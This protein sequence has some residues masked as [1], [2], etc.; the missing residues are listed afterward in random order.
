VN[1]LVHNPDY[2]AYGFDFG[3]ENVVFLPIRRDEIRE[4][5]CLKKEFIDPDR[6]FV[7]VPLAEL[8][9]LVESPPQGLV[10]NPPRFIFHT[11]YCASTFLS[12]CLDVEGSSVSLRE[13][14]LLL[15]AAN[16]KRMQWQSKT[17]KLDHRHFPTLALALLQKHATASE[18]L[19][20]KPVNSVNNI[21][22]E[23]LQLASPARSLMLYTDARNFVLSTL[24]KGE[25]GKQTI[26]SMFD[27]L[28]CDFPHLS[29]LQLTHAI[30]MTDLRI[31]M[32]LWRLQLEQAEAALQQ[33]A[34]GN[35][36][37]SL[38]GEELIE[39]PLEVLKA[40]NKLLDLG[41]AQERLE[42]IVASDE[43]FNDAKNAGEKF[44]KTKRA[45][46]YEK[47]EQFYGADLDDGLEWLQRN[48]PG[49]KLRPDLTGALQIQELPS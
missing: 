35:E 21:I 15:D 18:K 30:H 26:R 17:T 3:T 48:N 27:L 33:F 39:R 23:L 34:P 44:S 4:V 25:G 11:A 13:P 5:S 16:A 24:K 10:D 32:T 47:L 19:V 37:A 46:T 28:R 36:M 41:F 1:D 12:R 9:G 14:Q 40:T 20:I 38:Y 22:P 43:R 7:Q 42:A 8:V 29:N 2:L 49:C 6:Q 45:A 31:S